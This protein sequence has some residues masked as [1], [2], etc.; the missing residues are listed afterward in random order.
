[1]IC[2]GFAVDWVNGSYGVYRGLRVH[3]ANQIVT[4][5]AAEKLVLACRTALNWRISSTGSYFRTAI[6]HWLRPFVAMTSCFSSEQFNSRLPANPHDLF[7][8]CHIPFPSVWY[9][10]YKLDRKAM[11]NSSLLYLWHFKNSNMYMSIIVEMS[12]YLKQCNRL[13]F[14]NWKSTKNFSCCL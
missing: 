14:H 5:F 6:F 4:T 12:D 7:G 1:M 2:T 13:I 8:I 3:W 9:I 10:D 11:M